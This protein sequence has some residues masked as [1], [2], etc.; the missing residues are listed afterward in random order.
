MSAKPPELDPIRRLR[1]LA[2][3]IPGAA[4]AEGVLDAPYDAVWDAVSDFEH[5][6]AVEILIKQPR[7][8]SR[9]PDPQTGGERVEIEYRPRP[10]GPLDVIEVDLRPGWCWMQSPLAVAGMAAA[11]EG[12]RTRFAHL[13]A[14]RFPGRRLLG[15]LLRAK[16]G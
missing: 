15:P 12:E 4:V 9:R 13:E 11:P 1:A 16:M 7:I 8:R 3:A 2:A 5:A 14:V 6:G 10:V